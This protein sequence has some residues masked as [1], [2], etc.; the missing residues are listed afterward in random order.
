MSGGLLAWISARFNKDLPRWISLVALLI[1]FALIVPVCLNHVNG[2]ID[3]AQGTWLMDVY[4]PWIP[5]FGI[6]F[7][8]ALDGL[9]LLM[10][11]LTLFLGILSVLISW[12]EIKERIGFYYFNLMWI[13]AGITGVFLALDLFLFIFFWE[14]MLIPMYFLIGIWGSE[15]RRYAAFKFFLFTQASGLLMFV[16][17]LGLYFIHGN[18]TGNYSFDYF[19]L[20]GTELSPVAGRWLM[21]G[22]LIAFAVKLPVV[23]FHSW[24][25]DAHSEAPTAGSVILAGLLLKTG[26]YGLLRFIIPLFPDAS[27]EIAP[28]AML[29][30]VIG[31][32]YGAIL[33]FSQTDFKRLVAYTS[34]SHM[35]FV[36]LGVFA[37]N[38]LAYQ[39]VVMQMITHGISTGALFI[40]A[41]II[42]DRLHTRDI[43]QMGG[44]WENV[45][46]MGTA[47]LIFAMASLGLPGLGNFIAE[48]LTLMGSW[49][50]NPL[51]T[52]FATL[53]LVGA[54]VY[55]LRIMQRVFFG[56]R[57]NTHTF[58]DLNWRE[59]LIM[60][61]L[62][63]AIVWL[64]LY[65]QPVINI[66]EPVVK[67]L[68]Q[69]IMIH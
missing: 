64:G 36:I 51:M 49:Q 50:A 68:H 12:T 1:D 25:P 26:A 62:T 39:G 32:I 28:W 69:I 2:E 23:P 42:K 17:I 37:F 8:L 20:V 21:L 63:V 15:N 57:E 66:V 48:F 13:L 65:P 10:I 6:N 34:V 35:G 61:S 44:F 9:S 60:G 58:T 5:R 55:S 7:H 31:I 38:E 46:V 14:V 27:V 19:N 54:T 4:L 40:L 41:G 45:P 29:L 43:N 30:G 53:G 52:V 47:A 16:A 24:L 18:Q 59:I 67:G 11:L 33:A 22:F 3:P 56:P